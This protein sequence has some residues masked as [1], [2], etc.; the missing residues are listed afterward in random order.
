MSHN[1]DEYWHKET[2]I[3]RVEVFVSDWVLSHGITLG[4]DAWDDLLWLFTGEPKWRAKHP[5]EY[6][7]ELKNTI[8]N[9]LP[10]ALQDRPDK[11]RLTKIEKIV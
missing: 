11:P 7:K 6:V 9:E 2:W 5:S 8:F 4:D 3:D 10:A 1:I